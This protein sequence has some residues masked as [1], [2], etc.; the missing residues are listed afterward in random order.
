MSILLTGAQM[1]AREMEQISAG[2]VTGLELMERAGAGVVDAVLARWPRLAEAP[3]R[4]VILCGPGNNGGDGFVVARLLAVGGWAVQ[5][6]LLGDP[7]ALPPD[8]AAN[9][10]LWEGQG[11]TL[12]LEEAA[13]QA[14]G[15]DLVVDALFGT[16]L[17]RALSPDLAAL[18]ARALG[19][20]RHGVAVDILS[21]LC[22]DSGRWL[23][24]DPGYCADLTVTFHSA[25][26]GHVLG[27][28]G[29]AGGSLEVVDIGLPGE[30]SDENRGTGPGAEVA[31]LLTDPRFC[32]L[33]AKKQ[34]GA[35]KY[36]HGHALVLTGGAGKTGAARLAARAAL[37]IGAGLVTLGVAPGAEAEVAAQVTALMMQPIAG[38]S[39]LAALL[40]DSR[41][42]ALC[43]GPGLGIER[44]RELVPVAQE[45]A[46][47]GDRGLVLDADA[48]SAF[49]SDP[50]ALFAA[51]PARAV[52]TPHGG[53]FARLFPDLSERLSDPATR[54]PAFSRIDAARLA[55]QRAGCVVLMKG[56]DTV[57]A[58]PDRRVRVHA[59]LGARAAPWLATAGSGDVLSGV[60]CGLLARGFPAF[61]SAAMGVMLHVEAARHFGPGLIAEDLPEA[62]PAVLRALE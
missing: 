42:N 18:L 53:E 39:D 56:A 14:P 25:K 32:A 26:P 54:G 4:A 40:E 45:A 5:L 37:R 21:G 10:M 6:G 33:V 35:H 12:S 17:S 27:A 24:E 55:A 43:L 34:A 60:I 46:Q 52:L 57:I 11:K 8:A 13:G 49:G 29:E 44:A 20:A 16:G 28:G 9:K 62:L 30:G 38:A 3:G 23:G 50:Q 2:S 7:G 51:L 47:N 61:D 48:L 36:G 19:A 31:E 15:A 1:K 41:F 22:A 58:A 59:A